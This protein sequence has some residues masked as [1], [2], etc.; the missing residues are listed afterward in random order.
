[1]RQ[2]LRD[3]PRTAASFTITSQTIALNY[4]L[5]LLTQVLRHKSKYFVN[6]GF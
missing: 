5:E 2:F 1:L 3:N 4:H 6:E